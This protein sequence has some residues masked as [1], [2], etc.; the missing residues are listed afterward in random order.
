MAGQGG[1]WDSGGSPGLGLS[2]SVFLA[3]DKEWQQGSDP[4]LCWTR[5]GVAREWHWLERARLEVEAG[6]LGNWDSR[7]KRKLGVGWRACCPQ[8]MCGNQT[9]NRGG[10]GNRWSGE[11]GRESS[12]PGLG[13]GQV[14]KVHGGQWS[15]R[16][17]TATPKD[18]VYPLCLGEEWYFPPWAKNRHR[19]PLPVAF[20]SSS[21]RGRLRPLSVPRMVLWPRSLPL[22]TAMSDLRWPSESQPRDFCRNCWES[23]LL[24][25]SLKL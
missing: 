7:P 17:G 13:L 24:E 12:D 10:E 11:A 23:V 19:I 2:S 1:S 20:P 6:Q 4:G 25:C 14:I 8:M 18:Q 16:R 15:I 9:V 22:A 5:Y 3:E 21:S